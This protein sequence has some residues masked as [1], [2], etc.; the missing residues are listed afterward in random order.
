VVRVNGGG[1]NEASMPL[2]ISEPAMG[3][4]CRQTTE[5]RRRVE[6]RVV[7]LGVSV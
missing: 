6:V 4:G 3:C 7:V 2:S 1:V 5:T